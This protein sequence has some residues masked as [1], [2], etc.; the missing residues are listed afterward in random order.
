[1]SAP[2]ALQ[3]LLPAVG[4]VVGS[5][6]SLAAISTSQQVL[7]FALG[8]VAT[9]LVAALVLHRRGHEPRPLVALGALMGPLFIPLALEYAQREGVARA[10]RVELVTPDHRPGPQVVVVV[11]S[12]HDLTERVRRVLDDL[13]EPHAVTLVAMIHYEAT[14]RTDWT[15]SKSHATRLLEPYEAAFAEHR[16]AM[17]LQPGLPEHTIVDLLQGFRDTIVLVGANDGPR[18]QAL[19]DD[20]VAD[21]VFVP[22]PEQS[23]TA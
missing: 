21:V 10:N 20:T 18:W 15:D 8:W 16:P 17:V 6:L 1:M 11:L 2:P 14:A 13:D 22:E 23:L 5:D 9:G 7:L 3:E 19:R 12:A 4:P